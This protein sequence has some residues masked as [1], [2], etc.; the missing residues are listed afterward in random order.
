MH[1]Y[2]C[3]FIHISNPHSTNEYRG[4]SHSQTTMVQC[5]Y[6]IHN[7]ISYSG[8]YGHCRGCARGSAFG[9]HVSSCFCCASKLI[10]LFY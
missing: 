5:L 2:D 10:V 9:R 4:V 3:C 7:L 8:D 6:K 1:R